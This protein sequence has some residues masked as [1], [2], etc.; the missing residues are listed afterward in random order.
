MK[1]QS[2]PHRRIA[3]FWI[4]AKAVAPTNKDDLV[5]GGQ[6]FQL[7]LRRIEAEWTLSRLTLSDVAGRLPGEA[8]H[9]QHRLL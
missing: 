4:S 7:R 1:V 9:E 5:F 6:P 8:L 2:H 3:G